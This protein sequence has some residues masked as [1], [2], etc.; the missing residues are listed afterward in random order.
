MIKIWERPSPKFLM[1]N[2]REALEEGD[3]HDLGWRGDTFTRSNKRGVTSLTKERLDQVVA[4]PGWNEK[5]RNVKLD[6]LA[7]RSSDHK[8]IVLRQYE[9]ER[10]AGA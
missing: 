9:T 2:F 1:E 6:V 7:A 8:P 3:L 10:E 4:N 5:H